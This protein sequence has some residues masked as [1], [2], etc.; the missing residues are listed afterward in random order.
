MGQYFSN[1]ELKSNI[2]KYSVDILDCDY[3]N[4]LYN[5]LI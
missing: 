5:D 4:H 3:D 2:Q 1:E